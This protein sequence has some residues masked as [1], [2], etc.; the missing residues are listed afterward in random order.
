LTPRGQRT[1]GERVIEFIEGVCVIP[2][3]PEVGEP[4]N[5]RDWQKKEICRIYDNPA[6]TRRAILSFGRKNAKTTLAAFLLLA[7]LC[8]PKARRNAQLYSTA[9]SQEQAALVFNAAVKMIRMSETLGKF[10]TIR[11]HVKELY[12]PSLGTQFKALSAETKTAYGLS[13]SLIIHDE[14]GQARGPS[15][16]LFDAL[17]TATGAQKDPL[18]VIISTQA[19][20]DAD[21]LSQLIDNA[22]VG[23]NP[24]HIV[25]LYTAPEDA[26]PFSEETIKLANPAYGDFLL[27]EQVLDMAADA[28]VMPARESEYRNL[29]LNQRVDA[30]AP[31]VSRGVWNRCNA[32]PKALDGIPVYAGLDLSS[33][34]DLTAWVKMG[35]ISKVWQVHSTFWLPGHGIREKSKIDRVPYDVWLDQGHILAAPGKS[36]DYEY[37]AQFI[38]EEFKRYDLRKV[39]FDRWGM[40]HLRPWLIK[41][42]LPE[43]FIDE[44]FVAFGQ[45]TLSMTPALRVLEGRLLNAEIAHGGNPVL[46]MCAANAVVEGKDESCRRLSKNKSTGRIDGM[47]ALAMAFGI[48]PLEDLRDFKMFMI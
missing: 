19:P 32:T 5:L 35:S 46:S 9:Q 6:G 13:P 21:L 28:K 16:P 48:A 34:K 2:E 23:D 42:G 29:V 43:T 24:K 41:A 14:L 36:V 37:V 31:F 40:E 12:C 17:E 3:G 44:R 7:H 20:T 18:T 33:T 39:G 4:V 15:S 30:S 25:S 8:G 27:K 1:E 45:G 47:V 10:I 22:L 26:D 11:S 38:A